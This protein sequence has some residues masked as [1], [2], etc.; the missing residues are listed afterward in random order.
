MYCTFGRTVSQADCHGTLTAME[1]SQSSKWAGR[2][3]ARFYQQY[4]TQTQDQRADRLPAFLFRALAYVRLAD[5]AMS[6]A[7]ESRLG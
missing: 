7:I 4:L 1:H 5:F 3:C 6:L 2:Y